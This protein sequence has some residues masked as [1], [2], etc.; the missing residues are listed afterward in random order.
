VTDNA[1]TMPIL[2]PLDIDDEIVRRVTEFRAA[3]S[4]VIAETT[5][6]DMEEELRFV[7]AKYGVIADLRYTGGDR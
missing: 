7:W 5:Q 4:D 3:H 6:K 2:I 1:P